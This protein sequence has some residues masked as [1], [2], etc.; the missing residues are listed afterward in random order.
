MKKVLMALTAL[1]LIAVLPA[2]TQQKSA[3]EAGETKPAS[4]QAT[5]E[6]TEERTMNQ[7]LVTVGEHTFTAT[8]YENDAA[9]ALWERLP[10][11][12]PMQEL[13][14]NEKYY[15]L[16]DALPSAP[17]LPERIEN[18]DIK[19]FGSDCLVLFYEGFTTSYRYTDIG[20]IDNPDGLKE[21]LG[22]GDVTVSFTA[23]E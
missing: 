20:K 10:L 11:T 23:Q 17:S 6:T 2:C 7:M 16:G 4:Q 9:K 18:G 12:L 22:S 3:A 1:L 13:H 21:A 14:G 19:L 15:Y 8:L 5:A